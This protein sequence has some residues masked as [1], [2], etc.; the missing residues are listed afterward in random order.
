MNS[1]NSI[2]R[3]LGKTMIKESPDKKEQKTKDPT[4]PKL[5]IIY[6]LVIL[7]GLFAGNAIFNLWTQPKVEKTSSIVLP[8]CEPI[9]RISAPPTHEEKNTPPSELDHTPEP[10]LNLNGVFVQN[11]TEYALIDNQILKVEDIIQGAKVEEI[12]LEK[13]VLGF[14]GRKITLINSS[15]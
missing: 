10:I 9:N 2:L 3:K 14:K 12:S 8:A 7:L 4:K 1:I 6:I 13:V 5:I 11:D 15:K